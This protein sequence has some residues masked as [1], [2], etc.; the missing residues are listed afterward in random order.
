MVR[1][2]HASKIDGIQ[3]I[4]PCDVCM[5]KGIRSK[6]AYHIY[7]TGCDNIPNG[8]VMRNNHCDYVTDKKVKI[9]IDDDT[10]RIDHKAYQPNTKKKGSQLDV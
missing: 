5:K 7:G 8:T 4:V 3:I 9:V 10:K 6:Y 2:V 1:T